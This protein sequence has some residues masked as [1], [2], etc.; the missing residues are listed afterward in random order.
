M[1]FSKF[2]DRALKKDA[3]RYEKVYAENL[4]QGF[5][6][7]LGLQ[8][9]EEIYRKPF[10]KYYELLEE[11][12]K[13]DTNILELGCGTG[14]HTATLCNLS[15]NVTALDISSSAV[16]L[17]KRNT[18]N[19]VKTIVGS[20]DNIPVSDNTFDLVVSCASFSYVEWN[21]LQKEILRDSKVG[22]SVVF[23]DSLNHNPIYVL[24]RFIHF[25]MGRR[26]LA[27]VI[28][29]PTN[30][31]LRNLLKYYQSNEIYYF[32]SFIWVRKILRKWP[33][34]AKGLSDNLESISFLEILS[35]RVVGLGIN[36]KSKADSE[37]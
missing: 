6:N 28:R 19:L 15:N 1:Q 35:F 16:E 27:T 18:N 10:I 29:I 5:N 32:D 26:T 36:L 9:V 30:R 24:N 22:S 13:P 20:M 33:S 21:R 34:V 8:G 31:K 25:V 4:S 14:L 12:I 23:L 37:V 3:K 17:C 11:I 7:K 2:L